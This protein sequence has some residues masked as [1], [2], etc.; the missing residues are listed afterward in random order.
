MPLFLCFTASR[1]AVYINFIV[2]F[3]CFTFYIGKGFGQFFV[4]VRYSFLSYF[5]PLRSNKF[6]FWQCRR[7]LFLFSMFQV[8]NT[9]E[10]L[11]KKYLS[12]CGIHGYQVVFFT[13]SN[14]KHVLRLKYLHWQYNVTRK[15]K[16]HSS[17]SVPRISTYILNIILH[18]SHKSVVY[19]VAS[20]YGL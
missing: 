16:H 10:L 13:A 18:C 15:K 3:V 5:G 2:I 19:D 14:Y 7:Y 4:K 1:L 20:E 9:A 11:Q 8:K 17:F 6:D 12:F